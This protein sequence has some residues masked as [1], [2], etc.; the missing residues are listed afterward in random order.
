[1]ETEQLKYYNGVY[2]LSYEHQKKLYSY[3]MAFCNGNVSTPLWRN[4]SKQALKQ[5]Q[6]RAEMYANLSEPT[7]KIAELMK[8]C[9]ER[10][11]VNIER[12]YVLTGLDG[13]R[14][15]AGIY[16]IK[17]SLLELSY[18]YGTLYCILFNRYEIEYL[19][20]YVKTLVTCYEAEQRKIED[21]AQ[22]QLAIEEA[23]KVDDHRKAIIEQYKEL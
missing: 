9:P 10:F 20:P 22:L 12:F 2:C 18:E 6:E 3:E 23:R 11:V 13:S 1:M 5:R 7:L 19:T 4:C 15:R 21:D 14:S 16:T 8:S 17:D